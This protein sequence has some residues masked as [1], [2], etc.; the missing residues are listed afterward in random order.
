MILNVAN[1]QRIKNFESETVRLG[2]ETGFKL[3]DTWFL[4][5]SSQEGKDTNKR[6]PF[7]IF[8]R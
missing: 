3:K 8:E 1:T 2:T 7:F 5:L 6:E 4:Q